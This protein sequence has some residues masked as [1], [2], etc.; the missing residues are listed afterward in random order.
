MYGKTY[1]CLLAMSFWIIK[2]FRDNSCPYFNRILHAVPKKKKKKSYR[3][4]AG[5]TIVFD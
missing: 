5:H 1:F 3:S 2:R 4:I